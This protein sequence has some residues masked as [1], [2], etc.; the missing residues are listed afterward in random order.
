VG[1][2]GGAEEVVDKVVGG[3]GEVGGVIVGKG[4]IRGVDG[5]RRL[6]I[7]DRVESAWVG[8]LSEGGLGARGSSKW[9]GVRE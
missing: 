9:D 5:G 6:I 8:R 1:T 4:M 2:Q 3:G 7:C